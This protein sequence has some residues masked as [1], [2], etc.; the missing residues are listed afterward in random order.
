MSPFNFSTIPIKAVYLISELI[1][2]PWVLFE[3][4]RRNRNITKSVTPNLTLMWFID[5]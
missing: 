3:P 2:G 4:I 5:I 1:T